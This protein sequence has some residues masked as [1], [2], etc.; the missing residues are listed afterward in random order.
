MVEVL[1]LLHLMLPTTEQAMYHSIFLPYIKGGE[2]IVY[3]M[4]STDRASELET[5]VE[6][7]YTLHELLK[8]N[9]KEH[10]LFQMFQRVCQKHFKELA[11]L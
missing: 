3:N 5:L 2:K 11:F 6:V 10:A 9:Y 8:Q 4:N 1:R 7:Y